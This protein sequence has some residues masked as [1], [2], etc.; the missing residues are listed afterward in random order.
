M[1]RFLVVAP[2]WV[3]DA[4]L[5]QPMVT[6]LK[7]QH[8]DT[9]VDVLGPPW[10][11]PIYRR[12]PEIADTLEGAFAHGELALGARWRLGRALRNHHYERAYVLPNSFKS[13]LLPACAGIPRRIGYVGEMRH[14]LLTDAR[15]LDKAAL[16]RMVERFAALALPPGT[17]LPDRMPQPR[18]HVD[19]TQ[20]DDLVRRLGLASAA[21][22]ACFCPGA[23]F[24]PAKRWPE[25]HFATL[26]ARMAADGYAVWLI[27]S[28]KERDIG[29]EIRSASGNTA[30]NLCGR[31]SL[32]EAVLLLARA[33]I[34][35]SN[36]SGLMHVAA[37]LGRPLVALY[38]SS[39][40]A[41]TPP[42][43]NDARILSLALDCSPCF[44][45]VCPLGHFNC[46][47]QL[48]PGRVLAEI[49]HI[50]ARSQPETK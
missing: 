6:L 40:P 22:V 31:T 49:A 1:T 12:M 45:R 7:Q 48:D 28:A 21:R 32:D 17:P 35:V 20:R 5:S 41:F 34:V 44:Q 14:V 23:E 50:A 18:L 43:S 10:A 25:A 15:R 4:V 26:A 37:A 19:P 11:L 42:L 3:G 8:P 33:D 9:P 38:G 39:S 27:G 29:E 24:G 30:V 36:D 2:A 46:M 47:M 16:P 13:A